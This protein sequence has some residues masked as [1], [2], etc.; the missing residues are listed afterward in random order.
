MLAHVALVLLQVS[1]SEAAVERTFSAQD[2]IHTKRRNRLKDE[3]IESELFVKVTSYTMS[4]IYVYI[5]LYI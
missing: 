1:A 4:Y 5:L 3:I 2:Q